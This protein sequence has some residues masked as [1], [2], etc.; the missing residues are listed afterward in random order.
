MISFLLLFAYRDVLQQIK[1]SQ[2][3]SAGSNQ[4]SKPL[5]LHSSLKI[6][7]LLLTGQADPPRQ[8]SNVK[9]TEK[10]DSEAHESIQAARVT[11][12]A[13]ELCREQACHHHSHGCFWPHCSPYITGWGHISLSWYS[14]HSGVICC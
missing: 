14:L 3:L 10:T 8:K 2:H 4:G 1:C 6:R 13:S 7:G 9:D 5:T 12:S 11:E